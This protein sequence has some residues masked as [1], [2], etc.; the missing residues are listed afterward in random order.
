MVFYW[1]KIG[2]S[3]VISKVCERVKDPKLPLPWERK[4]GQLETAL[5]PSARTRQ[6]SSP[7]YTLP[8]ST[9]LCPSLTGDLLMAHGEL[10]GTA[11]PPGQEAVEVMDRHPFGWLRK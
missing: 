6:P 11:A 7:L 2:L 4:P 9:V 1:L 5:S 8:G 10:V 3:R